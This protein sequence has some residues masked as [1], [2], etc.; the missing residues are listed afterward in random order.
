MPGIKICNLGHLPLLNEQL[1]MLDGRLELPQPVK[2][3]PVATAL[4]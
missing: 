2:R 4:L 3:F 1:Q